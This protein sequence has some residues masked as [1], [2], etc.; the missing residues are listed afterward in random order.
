MLLESQSQ[1][2]ALGYKTDASKIDSANFPKYAAGQK[3]A[4]CQMYVAQSPG[5]AAGPCA[6]YPG[7]LVSAEGWCDAFI[8]RA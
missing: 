3:C 5:T 2:K 8:K 4:T 6:I 1:A 7:K